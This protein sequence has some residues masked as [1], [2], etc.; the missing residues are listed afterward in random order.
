VVELPGDPLG[1]L[2]A[3][4]VVVGEIHHDMTIDL[5]AACGKRAR[6]TAA[7]S[8]RCGEG[9]RTGGRGGARPGPS[10]RSRMTRVA[11][12]GATAMRATPC[13]GRARRSPAAPT[14]NCSRA[15]WLSWTWACGVICSA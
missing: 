13:A 2:H 6:E 3:R 1:G 4:G 14:P 15:W 12:T 11:R 5:S 7:A 10:Y 9:T 8:R